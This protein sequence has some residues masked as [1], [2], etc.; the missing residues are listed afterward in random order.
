MLMQSQGHEVFGYSLDPLEGGLF[1]SANLK[2]KIA[3]DVRGNIL[4]SSF[5][6]RAIKNAKPDVV[7]HMAAQPLV[8]SSYVYPEE[9]FQVNVTGTLNLLSV[10]RD[11][12]SIRALAIITTDKVY[13]NTGEKKPYVE[14]DALGSSDPYSTSKAMADL[15]TQ[16]WA[17]NSSMV[18]VA[19]LR[20]GNVI[21]GGDVSQDRL[22]PDLVRAKKSG[23]SPSL[24]NPSA[25]RPWQHVLDCLAGYQK[26]IEWLLSY[27]ENLILNIG[28]M[29]YDY[30][31]V[32][33]VA[34]M[35]IRL[36][37]GKN[38]VQTL[39]ESPPEAD[40]L[41]LDSSRARSILGWKEAYDFKKAIEVTYEWFDAQSQGR[42]MYEVSLKQIEEFQSAQRCDV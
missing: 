37:N 14:S 8:R 38:W 17:K 29:A 28:P 40:F 22:I 23:Q 11:V 42:D 27:E 9:T 2:D 39:E 3:S 19:I 15:L 16:S 4:D 26:T 10:C 36:S 6:Q 41:T 12:P 35:F 5:L 31:N 33:E 25:V 30:R 18:P 24:R 32:G 13:K 7:V 1:Q 21:G 34:E 20:A